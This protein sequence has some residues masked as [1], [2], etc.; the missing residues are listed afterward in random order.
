MKSPLDE[1]KESKELQAVHCMK[2]G[3]MLGKIEGKAEIKC[4]RCKTINAYHTKID[5]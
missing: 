2:C 5:A 1:A 3:K 4:T